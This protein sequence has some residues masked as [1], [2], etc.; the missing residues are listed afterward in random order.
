MDNSIL[1]LIIIAVVL[2]IVKKI[3]SKFKVP[4]IGAMALV[5][6]GVKCGKSTLSVAIAMS[7]FK[8]RTRR[9][10]INNF[11]RK[12]FKKPLRPKSSIYSVYQLSPDT[13]E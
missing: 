10:R 11:F 5:S 13:Y 12:I 7:E 9:V 1:I 6:G 3:Q 2:F 4:K 8:R